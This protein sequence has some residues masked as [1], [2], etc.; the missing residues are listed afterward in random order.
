MTDLGGVSG[1]KKLGPIRGKGKQPPKRQGK[2]AKEAKKVGKV[3]NSGKEPSKVFHEVTRSQINA[4][5]VESVKPK[6]DLNTLKAPKKLTLND[7][8]F[9]L[10]KDDVELL[11]NQNSLFHEIKLR[12]GQIKK[13][14]GEWRE[15]LKPS[16]MSKEVKSLMKTG[17]LESVKSGRG[18]VYILK[19]NKGV[20][21]FV[22]KPVDEHHDW[23]N[24]GKGNATPLAEC[25]ISP[26]INHMET[27]GNGLLSYQI[28]KELGVE[29]IT[30]ETEIMILKNEGFHDI[31]DNL[32]DGNKIMKEIGGPDKEKLCSVQRFVSEHR[33][34]MDI[35]KEKFKMTKNQIQKLS[36]EK[37]GEYD[38]MLA[39]LPDII[40]NDYEDFALFAWV[41]GEMDGNPGNFMVSKAKKG[42]EHRLMKIDNGMTFSRKR[43]E[44][45]QGLSFLIKNYNKPVSDRMKEKIL[46]IN[47]G[48]VAPIL[49]EG[50]KSFVAI[51]NTMSRIWDLQDYLKKNK[52][53]KITMK[54]LDQAV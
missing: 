45:A 15:K 1:Q 31:T 17:R 24:N 4:P 26:G 44:S 33:E 39:T 37:P 32:K 42:N 48:K 35:M 36:N 50:D 49:E 11:K 54:D 19:N 52:G 38:K 51:K 53:K 7:K 34:L 2:V 46:T 47:I 22:I 28:A 18:G 21:L 5:S 40:Q 12:R 9:H 8:W 3:T 14:K 16:K 6:V 43:G 13:I 25:E 10:Y 41:I 20:P 29:H 23:L 27:V 30:P